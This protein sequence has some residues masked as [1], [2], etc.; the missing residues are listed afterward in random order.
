MK[1]SLR[2]EFKSK[3]LKTV[4]LVTASSVLSEVDSLCT[5]LMSAG[6]HSFDPSPALTR[7]VTN[8][9]CTLVFS[10]TYRQGDAELQ[11]VLR[12][13]DGIVQTIARGALVDI[14]PWMK[15]RPAQTLCSPAEV[16]S[17]HISILIVPQVFPNKSL[18]QLKECIVVRDRLLSHKLEEHKVPHHHTELGVDH[19]IA[20]TGQLVL[21]NNHDHRPL[22]HRI[23]DTDSRRGIL[24]AHLSTGPVGSDRAGCTTGVTHFML[25]RHR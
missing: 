6:A 1:E 10:A 13:N 7:A 11:E 15:V 25:C 17:A 3:W 21:Q 23:Y 14:Y 24:P 22:L 20:P 5:E 2:L 8:V 16:E 12:Y 18:S 9:V 19:F 4:F